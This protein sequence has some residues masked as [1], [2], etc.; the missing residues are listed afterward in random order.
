MGLG[1]KGLNMSTT[2]QNEARVK[3]GIE[4]L[5]KK[6]GD[7]WVCTIDLENL[8]I[9][10]G[11]YCILGQL[12]EDGYFEGCKKLRIDGFGKFAAISY[13]FRIWPRSKISNNYDCFCC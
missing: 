10:S 8:N 3:R 1:R 6:R 13:I 2:K 4:W 5:D 9:R 11:N 7:D 12:Y